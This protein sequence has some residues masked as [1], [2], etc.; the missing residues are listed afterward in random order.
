MASLR[1]IGANI[2]AQVVALAASTLDRVLLVAVML[3]L[4]GP[5][6]FADYAVLQSTAALLAIGDFGLQVYVQTAQQAA[7]A[8]GDHSAFRRMSAIHAYVLRGFTLLLAAIGLVALPF[9]G[10]LTQSPGLSQA[11]ATVALLLFGACNLILLLR[12]ATTTMAVAVGDFSR[13]VLLGAAFQTVG[14]LACLAVVTVGGGPVAVAA[15]TLVVV[16]IGAQVG[17]L[18]DFARRHPGRR[19]APARP[20]H[21]EWRDLL[22]QLRWVSL[23]AIVP[24]VWLQAPVLLL[25]AAG[26]G[27]TAIAAFVLLRTLVNMVRQ[28][29][30]FAALG[31][32]L[33]ISNHAHRGD[34]STA[35]QLSAEIGRVVSALSGAVGAGLVVFGPAVVTLWTGFGHLYDAPVAMMLVLP[36]IATAP[37]QQI[38][39]LLQYTNQSRIPGLMRLMQ[40]GFGAAFVPL[41]LFA[42]GVPGAAAGL[43]AAEIAAVA[44]I[45]PALTR[46]RLF[47]AL[48]RQVS[49][50][51]AAAIGAA[52]WAGLAGL[53]IDRALA[54]A[55]LPGLAAAGIL[56]G[57]VGLMPPLALSVPAAMR[58]RLRLRR[59]TTQ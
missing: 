46:T 8:R 47:P 50:T 38:V 32:G 20:S 21:A 34:F 14:T 42:A 28:F 12:S 53:A 23:A 36:A 51:F 27:G 52:A 13:W 59:S 57:L 41:G 3:R 7:V 54:P 58:R 49:L 35:W 19:G 17:L 18:A 40:L 10:A 31:A 26:T 33:E 25:A 37:F 6:L 44:A 1:R 22:G 16:G 4:W 29:F 48:G 2:V 11:D 56:W 30:Q 9:S 15:T 55:T 24:V 43:A 5:E 45:L 39:A